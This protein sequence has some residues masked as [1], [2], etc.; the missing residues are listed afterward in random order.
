MSERKNR[1]HIQVAV[2]DVDRLHKAPISLFQTFWEWYGS[3]TEGWQHVN[4]PSVVAFERT[5]QTVKGSASSD[6]NKSLEEMHRPSGSG[7]SSG[8]AGSSN[9]SSSSSRGGG[10]GVGK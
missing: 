5:C 4:Y 8:G 9:S 1:C 10:G 2:L 3:C 7:G 6:R